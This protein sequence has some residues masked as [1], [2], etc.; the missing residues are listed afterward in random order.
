MNLLERKSFQ[1][2]IKNIIKTNHQFTEYLEILINTYP[3]HTSDEKNAIQL[4]EH[5]NN[6]TVIFNSMSDN[7]RKNK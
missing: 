5:L 6:M 3:L 4:Q 7:V 1:K 2:N